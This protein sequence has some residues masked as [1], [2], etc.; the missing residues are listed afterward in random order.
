LE[1]LVEPA[2]AHD[3]EP[4]GSI[5]VYF[6]SEGSCRQ[7]EGVAGRMAAIGALRLLSFRA[8]NGSSCAN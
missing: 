1:S 4:D 6:S 3:S 5:G 8:V 2:D 7:S